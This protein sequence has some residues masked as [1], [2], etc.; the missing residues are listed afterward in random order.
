MPEREPAPPL[1]IAPWGEVLQ[2]C[3][4]ATPFQMGLPQR[5]GRGPSGHAI[6]LPKTGNKARPRTRIELSKSRGQLRTCRKIQVL[7]PDCIGCYQQVNIL[8]SAGIRPQPHPAT[9]RIPLYLA[10]SSGDFAGLR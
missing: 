5:L 4:H 7:E 8:I 3:L 6:A 10:E 1:G 9:D 2:V